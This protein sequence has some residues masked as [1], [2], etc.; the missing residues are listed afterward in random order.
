MCKWQGCIG[1]FQNW[2]WEVID[3]RG[4]FGCSKKLKIVLKK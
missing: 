2:K 3:V 4:Q 1:V